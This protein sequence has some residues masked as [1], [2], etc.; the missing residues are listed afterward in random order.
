[1]RYGQND[2][3]SELIKIRETNRVASGNWTPN[4]EDKIKSG[5]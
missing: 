4:Y 5:S 3:M 1:M 2:D